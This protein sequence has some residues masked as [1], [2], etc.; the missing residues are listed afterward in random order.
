MLNPSQNPR[1]THATP[2]IE[3]R[4]PRQHRP[5]FRPMRTLL[6]LAAALS[7]ALCPVISVSQTEVPLSGTGFSVPGH[8]PN[9]DPALRRMTRHMERERNVE[10]QKK[11]VADTAQ[12]LNLAKELNNAVSH[13]TKDTLSL[14]VVKKADEIE[15]LAKT[16]KQKMRDG[17]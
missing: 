5:L 8:P 3:P 6:L 7:F 10:R 9:A 4:K 15:K 14:D 16:I 2:L 1:Q 17:E 12:L 13:S 11:I